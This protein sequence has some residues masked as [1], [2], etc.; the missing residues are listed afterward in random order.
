MTVVPPSGGQS[1]LML[2]WWASTRRLAVGKAQPG[3]AGFRGEEWREDLL[4]NLG[5]NS[6]TGVAD[7]NLAGVANRGS[8]TRESCRV[9]AWRAR[10]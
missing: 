10:R 3:P 9:P 2:P 6:W 5:R 1:T 4:A 8:A 7:R